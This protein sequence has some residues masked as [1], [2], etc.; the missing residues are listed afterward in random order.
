M[1]ALG[2]CG[3][4]TM[5]SVVNGTMLRGFSFPNADRLAGI[6]VIDV[7][8]RTANING[9]GGQIF[10]LDY[11]AMR[12]QQKSFDKLAAYIAGATVNVTADGKPQRYTGAY[13]SADFF[14]ILGV[15]PFVGRESPL[16]CQERDLTL[17]PSGIIWIDENP[18]LEGAPG[19]CSVGRIPV[20]L[21]VRAGNP[22]RCA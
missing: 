11:E 17:L 19:R 4:T 13:V 20:R 21:R 1:L 7:T 5:Y 9:F 15:A 14:R 8:Q 2:I 18:T 22:S 3:V 6:Q 10:T 12:E 16:G